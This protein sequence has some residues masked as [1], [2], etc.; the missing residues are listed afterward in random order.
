MKLRIRQLRTKPPSIGERAKR[1][2]T[3]SGLNSRYMVRWANLNLID[4][5]NQGKPVSVRRVLEIID[6]AQQAQRTADETMQ[7]ATDE[8]HRSC[9]VRLNRVLSKLNAV[10]LRYDCKA[11]VLFYGSS[12]HKQY[13][14]F[15]DHLRDL[16]ETR[17][18]AFLI[19]NLALVHRFRRCVDCQRWFIAVTDHQ[20]YCRDK[21]RKRHA[22]YGQSFKDQRRLYMREYRSKEKARDAIAKKLAK[23]K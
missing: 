18:V 1:H 21:C 13:L 15:S 6:L 12:L 16:S 9:R 10:L 20:K 23:G 3:L 7:S 17:A 2:I 19:E 22:A 11:K 5:L 4:W 14:F 8:Q